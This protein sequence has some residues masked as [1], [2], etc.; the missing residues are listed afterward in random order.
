MTASIAPQPAAKPRPFAAILRNV[1]SNWAALLVNTIISFVLSPVV[2]RGLGST[3]YGVWSL[4]TQFT[5]YLWLFDFGVRESVIKYVAQHH[6]AGE[7][8]ALESTIGTAVSVYAM[9]STCA[10]VAVGLLAAALPHLFNIPPDAVSAAQLATF[11]TGASVAQSFLAN[12][13]VGVLMGLQ[14]FYHVARV[15]TVFSLV[16]GVATYWLEFFEA[17]ITRGLAKTS[18]LALVPSYPPTS[19]WCA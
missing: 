11:F 4:L 7:R 16:R 9:V 3:Y 5:G 8:Q 17:V 1:T 6:A 14:R 10:L 18:L 13:Y 12:V 15:G 19:Q 2:V